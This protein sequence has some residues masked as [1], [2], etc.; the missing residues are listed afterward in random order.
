MRETSLDKASLKMTV[1]DTHKLKIQNTK[2]A[3]DYKWTSSN[4]SVAMV[5]GT[6]KIVALRE[7]KATITA[8][9]SAVWTSKKTKLKCTVEVG[10]AQA[11]TEP[12]TPT[13]PT[14]PTTPTTPTEPTKPAELLK[15][16]SSNVSVN[17]GASVDVV[18]TWEGSTPHALSAST[19]AKSIAD[20]DW[21]GDGKEYSGGYR[22]S[23][24]ITGVITG[25]TIVKVTN[26]ASGDVVLINVTVNYGVSKKATYFLNSEGGALWATST[27]QIRTVAS[28]TGYRITLLPTLEDLRPGDY[29]DVLVGCVKKGTRFD[30]IDWK[31]KQGSMVLDTGVVIIDHLEEGE[32]YVARIGPIDRRLKFPSAFTYS[33]EFYFD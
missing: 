33:L 20:I 29:T 18:V 2:C 10:A 17:A 7:G 24:R 23:L 30:A 19:A 21:V 27:P 14:E 16:S 3:A 1:G 15:V 28:D 12:T 9:C 5:S 13:T 31:L 11:P 22:S 32:S 25:S 8:S 6:G 26:K 4:D